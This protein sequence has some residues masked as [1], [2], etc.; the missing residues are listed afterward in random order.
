M[1]KVSFTSLTLDGGR[2]YKITRRLQCFSTQTMQAVPLL[3]RKGQYVHLGVDGH[4]VVWLA[5]VGAILRTPSPVVFYTGT[6]VRRSGRTVT[7]RDGTVL[8]LAAGVEP[9]VAKGFLQVQID[10]A[11]HLVTSMRLP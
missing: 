9:P 3:D 4:T 7:F 11:R 6:L 5:A 10:P 8:R 2:T 1:E